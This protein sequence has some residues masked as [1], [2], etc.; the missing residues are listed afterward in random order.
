MTTVLYELVQGHVID[1]TPWTGENPTWAQQYLVRNAAVVIGGFMWGIFW[2]VLFVIV[3][4]V[5]KAVFP[6]Y[7]TLNSIQRVDWTS[8]YD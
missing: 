3:D 4:L 8:R 1:T 6:K 7:K 2:K 5:S